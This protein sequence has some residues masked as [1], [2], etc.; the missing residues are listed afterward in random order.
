MEKATHIFAAL[1]LSI[2][3]TACAGGGADGGAGGGTASNNN[4]NNDNNDNIDNSLSASDFE[5]E[6]Y[7]NNLDVIRASS[8]YARNGTGDGQIVAVL[9][10]PFAINHNDLRNVFL[11]G[12]DASDGDTDIDCIVNCSGHG[13]HVAGIIAGNKNDEVMHGV[14]YDAQ[15]K[16][17]AIFDNEGRSDVTS[18]QLINAIDAGSGSDI[19]VMNNS[20]GSQAIS[21]VTFGDRELYYE[22]PLGQNFIDT[23]GTIVN[24]TMGEALTTAWKNAVNDGTIVV[25][26]NGNNAL[27]SDNGIVKVYQ[28]S[29]LSGYTENISATELFGADNANVASFEGS[30]A[31]IESEL[32]GKWLSVVAVDSNN[33]IAS[34]SNGCSIAKEYCLAA[35]GVSI[36]STL[37]TDG[38]T[39]HGV[40][41]GTSMAAP[42]VSGALAALKSA[43]PSMSSEELVT[44]VLNTAD[45]LGAEGTDEVY[46]RGML[47]LDEASK[48]QGELL[49]VSSN[50]QPLA[51][52][53]LL[54]DSKVTL[55]RHFGG[56][57]N[58]L[59]IGIKDDYNRTFT[60]SPT[61]SI[62][63]PLAFGLDDYIA[64]LNSQA[65]QTQ[66]LTPQAKI[67]FSNDTQSNNSWMNANFASGVSSA[68]ITYRAKYRQ[69]DLTLIDSNK[70]SET[71]L[72]FTDIRPAGSDIAQLQTNHQLGKYVSFA[73]YA[74]KGAFD[75]G[76]DFSELGTDINYNKGQTAIN[77]GFGHL[78]ETNQFMGA[79]TSGAYALQSP[80]MSR[81][82]DIRVARK[83]QNHEKDTQQTAFT[84][85]A[86]YTSYQSNVDMAYQ[87]FASVK[88]LAANQY[89]IGITGNH[90]LQKDD[91]LNIS[92]AT[93]LGI[94]DGTLNQSTVDGYDADNNFN[95]VVKSY[96]LAPK[97]RHQQL[98]MT[99]QS[100]IPTL[101]RDKVRSNLIHN[102]KFFTTLRMDKNLQNQANLSQIEMVAGIQT[103]F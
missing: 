85:Y 101:N 87:N 38:D 52:G 56:V 79:T 84:L 76:N 60:A 92:L 24:H 21:R 34:F 4:N 30:Y 50:N 57:V 63:K 14:A 22:R 99:Y 70:G 61:Q 62:L 78:R 3:L 49:A 20:W 39:E 35:P 102:S 43:F 96:D 28:N 5:T 31:E 91:T 1:S 73:P 100:K 13:T 17:I 88:D 81:F 11:E 58:D 40:K 6:E 69:N 65:P 95:N 10:S 25:F 36:H 54:N 53:I 89:Q 74:A 51:D 75:T 44:L 68:N 48:P 42:H 97:K 29:D 90:I 82:T 46:G 18:A 66:Q 37:P 72:R 32:A 86:D 83:L 41:H 15:I 27:N 93:K 80:T 9:D 55:S 67:A 45:D 77:I 16:P 12:Y 2:L 98:A 59:Q 47:N 7:Q 33:T 26:A 19:V 71:H 8:L 94:T 23:D 64:N 103:K